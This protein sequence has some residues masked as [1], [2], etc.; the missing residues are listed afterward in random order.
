V[1]AAREWSAQ[2]AEVHAPTVNIWPVSVKAQRGI[3]PV[4]LATALRA[5]ADHIEAD[6]IPEL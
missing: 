4:H 1:D 5:L 3:H 6:G 2:H